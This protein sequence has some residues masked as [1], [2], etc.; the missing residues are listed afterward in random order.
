MCAIGHIY[1]LRVIKTQFCFYKPIPFFQSN[2]AII[3]ATLLDLLTPTSDGPP[4]N[5]NFT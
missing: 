3:L 2:E 1:Q 5:H 4:S